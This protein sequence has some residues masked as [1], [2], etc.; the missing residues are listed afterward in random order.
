MGEAAGSTRSRPRGPARHRGRAWRP[1]GAAQA[2]LGRHGLP[3]SNGPRTGSPRWEDPTNGLS[4]GLKAKGAGGQA[5]RELAGSPG[6]WVG[7]P[8]A[9]SL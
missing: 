1:S 2:L 6:P 3:G 4:S 9:I 8:P 5:P 7:R